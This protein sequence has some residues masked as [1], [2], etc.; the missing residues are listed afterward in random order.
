MSA[1][2][3]SADH[4]PPPPRLADHR[5]VGAVRRRRADDVGQ[6]PA[7][8]AAG[9]SGIPRRV[10]HRRDRNH[11][12][13]LLCRLPGRVSV[14]DARARSGRPHSGLC[15]V[16]VVGVDRGAVACGVRQCADLVRDAVGHRVLHGRLVRGGRE[17]AERSNI[18]EKRGQTLSIYMVVTMGGLTGGQFLLNVADPESFELFVIASV[19][20]SM[21]L[22]PMALSDVRA[23]EFRVTESCRCA[24]CSRS[25]PRA[26]W[27]CSSVGRLPRPCSR[28]DP[29]TRR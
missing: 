16:G 5:H 28:S 6:R 3:G 25:F 14:H 7:G 12:S 21:S 10:R 8:N 23:P 4:D 15:G 20:V 19:L 13:R 22:V 9:R 17:L 24:S 2:V 1:Q 26:W 29:C 27:S 11:P 18:P